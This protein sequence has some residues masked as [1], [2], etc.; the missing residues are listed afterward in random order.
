MCQITKSPCVLLPR[1]SQLLE[2]KCVHAKE[3]A[4]N[5]QQHTVLHPFLQLH[6]HHPNRQ[7]LTL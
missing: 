6:P 4:I 1:S 3:R 7:H 5:L 2:P